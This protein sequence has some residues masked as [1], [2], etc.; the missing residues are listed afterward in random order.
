MER[1]LLL[2]VR[3]PRTH[4]SSVRVRTWRRLRAAGAVAL[5][6]G[7]YVLPATPEGRE[8]SQW[9]VRALAEDGG[10][11]MVVETDRVEGLRGADLVQRFRDARDADYRRLADA[12]RRLLATAGGA[13]EPGRAFLNALTRIERE[14]QRVREVDFF[15]APARWEVERLRQ[16]LA[17][18]VR[19]AADGRRTG[20]PPPVPPWVLPPRPSVDPLA[21]AWLVARVLEPGA[22][23]V[24]AEPGDAPPGA[25]PIPRGEG[26]RSGFVALLADTGL[27]EARLARLAALVEAAAREADAG[28]DAE[29]QALR[30]AVAAL[31]AALADDRALLAHALTFL[32]GL[33]ARLAAV[34]ADLA[35]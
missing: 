3:L 1:W 29:V 14:F 12:C 15:D 23:F 9:L 31:Q 20:E 33:A 19:P 13:D 24:F 34:P 5:R 32:D 26:G 4:A 6:R 21:C 7:V 11:A 22:R 8:R 27:R 25:R 35:R 30:L 2:L 18:R 16:A 10:E 28:R 17:R